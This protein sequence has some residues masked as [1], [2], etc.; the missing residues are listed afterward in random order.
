MNNQNDNKFLKANE[1]IEA[2]LLNMSYKKVGFLQKG[3]AYYIEYQSNKN[4]I[5]FLYGPPDYD[6]EMILYIDNKKYAFRDLY[7]IPEIKKWIE[8]HREHNDKYDFKAI[9]LWY[10]K[11]AMFSLSIITT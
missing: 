8:Q 5:E 11:L 2:L 6:I 3:Y 10:I 4:K 1:D 7:K 9:M